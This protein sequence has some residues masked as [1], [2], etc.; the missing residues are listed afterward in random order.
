MLCA[1]KGVSNWAWFIKLE[2]S[3][4]SEDT[5]EQSTWGP[6]LLILVMYWIDWTWMFSVELM[7][8]Q[9]NL[10]HHVP[11][12]KTRKHRPVFQI[13]S[14]VYECWVIQHLGGKPSSWALSHVSLSSRSL[15]AQKSH[16]SSLHLHAETQ[17]HI[18]TSIYTSCRIH[19]SVS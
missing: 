11:G 3:K 19:Q 16:V 13:R 5:S 1:F 10:L 12:E 15:R 8:C 9:G 2:N 4:C 7:L 14:C 6:L 17:T 18:N